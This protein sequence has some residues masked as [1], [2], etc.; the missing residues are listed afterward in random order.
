MTF[1]ARLDVLP[2]SRDQLLRI[3]AAGPDRARVTLAVL[4]AK[5]GRP[6]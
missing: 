3:L 4:A 2:L 5:K 1:S 6:S